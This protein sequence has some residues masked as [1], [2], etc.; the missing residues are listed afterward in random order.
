MSALLGERRLPIISPELLASSSVVFSDC[1]TYRYV[2]RRDFGCVMSTEARPVCWI[3]LNPS[4]ADL[5]HDDPTVARCRAFSARWGFNAM[6]VVNLFALRATSPKHLKTHP[7]P[8]GSDNDQWIRDT[9]L[10]AC[11]RGGIVVCAW[12]AHG[13][14][15]ERAAVVVTRV[16][17]GVPLHALAFTKHGEPRHPLYLLAGLE[18]IRWE[19]TL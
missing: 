7:D 11:A 2:L 12:G 10:D 8:V 9:A 4:T 5:L 1:G 6:W 13:A 16:L 3:M 15:H 17:E 18:P 19:P 14:L